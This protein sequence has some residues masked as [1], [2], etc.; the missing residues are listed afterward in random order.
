MKQYAI[1][2]KLTW[3][4][5]WKYISEGF[6][7]CESKLSDIDIHKKY[8]IFNKEEARKH[9]LDIILNNRDA[10]DAV[11]LVALNVSYKPYTEHEVIEYKEFN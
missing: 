11:A 10:I 2:I 3:E 7:L 5:D 6:A 1:R 8:F 4:K 9:Y